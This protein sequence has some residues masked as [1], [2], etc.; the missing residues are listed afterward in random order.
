MQLMCFGSKMI[1]VPYLLTKPGGLD[2]PQRGLD[3]DSQSRHCQE[4]SLDDRENLDRFKKLVSTTIAI[5]I[6]F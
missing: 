1:T 2:L 4:V 3:R 5:N 6:N